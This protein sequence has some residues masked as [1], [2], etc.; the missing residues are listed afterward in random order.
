[1]VPSGYECLVRTHAE[2]EY[3]YA[4]YRA[5]P[6]FF[7]LNVPKGLYMQHDGELRIYWFY[8]VTAPE[9]L[10]LQQWLYLVGSSFFIKH[11]YAVGLM[12]LT[13]EARRYGRQV[14]V[15]RPSSDSAE[16]S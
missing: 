10:L 5:D 12:K 4:K 9:L 6:A 2:R 15:V 14:D 8:G 1:M 16:R 11:G 3:F 7:A 13:A